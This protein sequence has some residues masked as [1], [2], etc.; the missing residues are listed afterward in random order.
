MHRTYPDV[1]PTV[2]PWPVAV[3]AGLA[4]SAFFPVVLA[5]VALAPAAA[6]PAG[7]RVA[8]RERRPSCLLDACNW[9]LA[10]ECCADLGFIEGWWHFRRPRA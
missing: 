5:A 4:L 1:P 9:Q 3:L 10:E 6:D 2:F 8:V 7:L